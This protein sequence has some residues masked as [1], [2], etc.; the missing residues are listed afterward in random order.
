[1]IVVKA[2]NKHRMD[3]RVTVFLGGVIDQGKA[4]NWAEKL[5][6]ELQSENIVILNPRRDNWDS[7]LPQLPSNPEFYNQVNWELDYQDLADIRAYVFSENDE[8][9]KTAL[10]P[11]TLLELGLYAEKF[12]IVCCPKTYWRYGNV[13]IV[14]DK[15]GITCVESLADL[16]GPLE[17]MIGQIDRAFSYKIQHEIPVR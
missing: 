16:I 8:E 7:S 10:A 14:C 11:I 15:M 17:L 9:A 5:T 2:P 12:N 4:S 1:M 6:N 13:R 3:D